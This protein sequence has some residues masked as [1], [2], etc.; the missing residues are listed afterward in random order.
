MQ[1]G[2]FYS[3]RKRK[4]ENRRRKKERKEETTNSTGKIEREMQLGTN[5]RGRKLRQPTKPGD[6]K[7]R[8]K[9]KG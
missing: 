3:N 5:A 4:E 2:W 9:L 1:L 6:R 7:L 8:I